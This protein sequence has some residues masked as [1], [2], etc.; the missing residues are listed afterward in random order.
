ME[1]LTAKRKERLL[2]LYGDKV[3]PI[4]K[5]QTEWCLK[6]TARYIWFTEKNAYNGHCERCGND[7]TYDTKTRHNADIT[8]PKCRAKLKV[9]HDWRMTQTYHTDWRAIIKVLD[10]SEVL[11]RYVLITTHNREKTVKEVAREVLNFDTETRRELETT[12]WDGEGSWRIGNKHKWFT[13]HSM[14]FQYRSLCCLQAD[15]CKLGLVSE[16]RKCNRFKYLENPLEYFSNNWYVTSEVRWLA[17]KAEVFEKLEKVGLKE[18]AE[19]EF[20]RHM[21]WYGQYDAPFDYTQTTLVGALRLTKTNYNRLFKY[22]T[23]DALKL[24]QNHPSI[25]DE[26]LDFILE[27][28]ISLGMYDVVC[29]INAG[30][31]IKMMKYI[32]EN[33]LS[34]REYEHYVSLLKDLEYELD[35]SYLFP[36]NFRK[37]DKR[38]SDEYVKNRDKIEAKKLQKQDGLIKAISEGLHKMPDLQE[39][40]SGSNGLLVYVPESTKDLVKESKALHNCLHTYPERVA[41]GKTLIFFVRR[42]N[43][44]TAPFIAFEYVNGD[45]VQCRYDNNVKVEDDKIIDFVEAFAERLRK[46]NVLYKAA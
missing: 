20:H 29:D 4:T 3:R 7:V 28:E 34:A 43:D 30:H 19:Q 44:P 18:L 14:N 36:K 22:K 37:A 32:K 16:L 35:K 5:A 2:N 41:E 23:L 1:R 31:E 21:S 13:E 26:V 46:N 39:F 25:K 15:P 40:L 10:E 12:D 6:D 27:N 38:V 45:V 17:E 11:I 24:M 42:L 9:R 33:K 8:C